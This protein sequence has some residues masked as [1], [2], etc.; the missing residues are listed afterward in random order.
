MQIWLKTAQFCPA[1]ASHPGHGAG[2]GLGEIDGDG[3]GDLPHRD[4]QQL[5]VVEH[6]ILSVLLG[7]TQQQ[8]CPKAL[9]QL[10]SCVDWQPAEEHHW[11]EDVLTINAVAMSLAMWTAITK[12]YSCVNYWC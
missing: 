2:V 4:G 5:T 7:N 3:P 9:L 12:A 1:F 8:C 6:P 11:A 10:D